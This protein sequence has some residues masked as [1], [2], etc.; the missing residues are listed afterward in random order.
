MTESSAPGST[1]KTVRS[2]ADVK[3]DVQ[4]CPYKMSKGMV[5]YSTYSYKLKSIN[6]WQKS[7]ILIGG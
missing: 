3:N 4:F 6:K 5:F 1:A 7:R 2:T